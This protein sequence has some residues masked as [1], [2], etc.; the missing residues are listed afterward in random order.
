MV[1]VRLSQDWVFSFFSLWVKQYP[2]IQIPDIVR[3]RW[4][5]YHDQHREPHTSGNP[6]KDQ[7]MASEIGIK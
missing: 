5:R 7:K 4:P 2:Q 3:G 6:G 1:Y